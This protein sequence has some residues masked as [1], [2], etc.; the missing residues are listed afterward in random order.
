MELNI[1]TFWHA[2]G[3]IDYSASAAEIGQNAGRITWD[4]SIEDSPQFMILDNPDKLSAF[5]NFVQSSGG[6]TIEEIKA[7]SD[8]ELNALCLQWISGD[9]REAFP[10][11]R[12][13]EDIGPEQWAEY[14]ANE[15][16]CHRLFLGMDGAV[17]FN[18]GS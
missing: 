11:A 5:Q 14:E 13:A 3:F 15:N 8:V 12:S 6:W 1:T 4:Q 10:G 9:A 2:A 18:V 16:F 17:Y 7:Y